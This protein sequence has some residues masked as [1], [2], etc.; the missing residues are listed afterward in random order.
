MKYPKSAQEIP[1]HPK[2]RDEFVEART[3][4]FQKNLIGALR[5][6]GDCRVNRAR[7]FAHV[8]SVRTG[9]RLCRF[10]ALFAGSEM[11]PKFGRRLAEDAFKG[12][13]ELGERLKPD[14]VSDLADTQARIEQPR[15][16]IF[17]PHAR[18]VVGEGQTGAAVEDFA[19]VKHT[20]SGRFRH[21]SEGQRFD[22]VFVDV[23]A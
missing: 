5:W 2:E 3:R 7:Y 12:A 14:V 19:K 16:G 23:I 13:I 8:D 20:C 1:H 4:S 9:S 6:R 10:A 18:D 15:P 17:Q 21:I 11:G 22:F